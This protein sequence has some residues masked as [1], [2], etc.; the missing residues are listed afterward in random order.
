MDKQWTPKGWLAIV[1]GIVFQPFTF[2]YVNKQKL[3]W[4]YTLFAIILMAIDSKLQINPLNEAWYK[5]LHFAWLLFPMYPIHAYFSTKNYD[6]NQ[7]RSWYASWWGTLIC[8]SFAILALITVRGFYFEPVTLP[9]E[10]MS[11]TLNLGDI[12]LVSKNGYGNYRY[13]GYQLLKTEPSKSPNRG[14]IVVFQSPKNPEID[15]I[16]RVIGLPGDKI[17]YR[18]KDIYIRKSCLKSKPNCSEFEL[19]KKLEVDSLGKNLPMY[20]QILDDKIFS[21]FIDPKATDRTKYYFNQPD[22]D[23]DEWVVP[24]EHYFVMGDNRDNSLD[25]RFFGFVPKENIIGSPIYIW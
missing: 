20:E 19:I 3:F 25:S 22:T 4:G 11:P 18:N 24:D 10:S 15:F 8:L 5:D 6:T 13:Y 21:I 1:F 14:D 7:K 9:S 16:K 23:K 17:I 12:A 2:L